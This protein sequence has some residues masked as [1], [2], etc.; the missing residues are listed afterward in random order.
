[1]KI[2]FKNITVAASF[3]FFSL[4]AGTA[5]SADHVLTNYFSVTEFLVDH[6]GN[7]LIR[8]DETPKSNPGLCTF[9]DWFVFPY[10][11]STSAAFIQGYKNTVASAMIALAEKKRVRLYI[12]GIDCAI[13]RPRIIYMIIES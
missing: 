13:S 8:T 3:V 10:S 7:L 12:S 11:T 1:M 4:V 9:T 6:V 5:S 2:L